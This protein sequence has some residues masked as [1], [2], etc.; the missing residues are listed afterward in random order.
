MA[1]QQTLAASADTGPEIGKSLAERTHYA[2]VRYAAIDEAGV[3]WYDPRDGREYF[4]TGASGDDL[5]AVGDEV[6]TS[7]KIIPFRP[8]DHGEPAA[9]YVINPQLSRKVRHNEDCEFREE[10]VRTDT[11]GKSDVVESLAA[12]REWCREHIPGYD[13]ADYRNAVAERTDIEIVDDTEGDR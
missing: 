8:S 7:V 10:F 3:I 6:L 5:Q 9:R 11:F 13:D 1:D 4:T 12:A 2:H